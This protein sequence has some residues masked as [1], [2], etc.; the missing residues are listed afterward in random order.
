[1]AAADTSLAVVSGGTDVPGGTKA[2]A[3]HPLCHKSLLSARTGE[4]LLTILGIR[5]II[6]TTDSAENL[7]ICNRIRFPKRDEQEELEPCIM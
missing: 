6:C 3:S 1:M 7:L 2:A 4:V 5:G